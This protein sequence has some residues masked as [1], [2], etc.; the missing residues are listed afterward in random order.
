MLATPPD[1]RRLDEFFATVYRPL[2]LR[3]RSPET[4]RL[5]VSAIAS[6]SRWLRR[7]ATLDDLEDLS[8]AAF[9]EARTA[10]DR[11][12]P[13]TVERERSSLMAL[14]RLAFE[15]RMIDRIPTCP[16]TLLPRRVPRAWSPEQFSRV[17]TVARAM[18]GQVG[19]VPAATFWPAIL[20]CAWETGE[21]VGA[22]MDADPRDFHR[23]QDGSA[24]LTIQPEARKGGREGRVYSLSP[25]TA[26]AVAAVCGA[27][28]V[29]PWPR[30]ATYLWDRLRVLF[31][32]A[33]VA[34]K[35][36]GFHQI[37]RTA[38]SH[39][40]AAG[41]DAAEFLGHA[42][43]SGSKVA[44]AWYVD[45]SLAPK[46]PAWELLPKVGDGSEPK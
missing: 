24:T 20:L 36:V 31:Q 39:Y 7:P 46:R 38:A 9:L 40:A 41:G 3:S 14:A 25:G 33:G 29:F 19:A 22:L 21:R 16:P 37:R 23:R 8:L 12:S 28:R 34:G 2:R 43:G 10:V 30:G 27:D 11:R 4:S 35:R 17:L 18:P 42:A 45:P 44:A 5:H 26:A 6:Y 13:Y 15:R 32:K 1:G